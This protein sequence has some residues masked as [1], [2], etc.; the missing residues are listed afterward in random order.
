MNKKIKTLLSTI[1]VTT[2]FFTFGAFSQNTFATA[3]PY[4]EFQ[5]VFDDVKA[6]SRDIEVTTGAGAII[7]GEGNSDGVYGLYVAKLDS[8]QNKT[9]QKAIPKAGVG[10]SIQQTSDNS[11]IAVSSSGHVVK[12]DSEG[13]LVW[14]KVL[15]NAKEL[16]SIE[17]TKDG[18]FIICGSSRSDTTKYDVYLCKIDEDGNVIFSY[19]YDDGNSKD[20]FGRSVQQTV[21]GGYIILGTAFLPAASTST[22][23]KSYNYLVKVNKN[24]N[25]L[26]KKSVGAADG[27]PKDLKVTKDG[28]FIIAGM[29]NYKG[30][31]LK[32]NSAGNLLWS[33]TLND[34]SIDSVELDTDG[35]M[36][37]GNVNGSAF[38]TDKDLQVIKTDLSG[39]KVWDYETTEYNAYDYSR[40]IT[41]NL[42]GSFLMVG[43]TNSNENSSVHIT[44]MKV[45]Y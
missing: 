27:M 20:D 35:F 38:S 4:V 22:T 30:V 43:D 23:T 45:N 5:T 33:K 42:D 41:K 17:P 10:N 9:W 28:S 44:L 2:S 21:D 1:L 7:C 24:G 32:T 14:D 29:I 26:W 16:T 13:N 39:N 34:W 31:L 8:N 11:Y 3:I 25:L 6:V 36:L 19:S 37:F 40:K 12:L 18:N 15:S